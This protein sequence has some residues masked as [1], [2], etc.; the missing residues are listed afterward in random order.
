MPLLQGTVYNNKTFSKVYIAA[1]VTETS[2]LNEIAL[3]L[4][5]HTV[6]RV[7]NQKEEFNSIL[8]LLKHKSC[9]IVY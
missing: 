2:Y 4:W 1:T 7:I 3:L 6:I 9:Q 5:V 8:F